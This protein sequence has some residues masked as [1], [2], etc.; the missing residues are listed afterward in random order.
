MAAPTNAAHVK[1]VLANSEPSTHGTKLPIRDVRSAV[2]IGG[3]VLQKSFCTGVQK[4]C[5]LQA[6]LPC[7]DVGT[8]SPHVKFTGDFGNAI[9]AIRIGDCF[10]FRVFARNSSPCN[11]R[12]L[13]HYRGISGHDAD[14]LKLTRS[15]QLGHRTLWYQGVADYEFLS[16]LICDVSHAF[17][18]GSTTH[19]PL[20]LSAG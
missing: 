20:V 6:R 9:E 19:A 8:S 14:R 16:S 3:I 2:A 13:Q 18:S 7:R 15:T 5:G 10:P 4:F 12:L 11:F 17:V 1:K